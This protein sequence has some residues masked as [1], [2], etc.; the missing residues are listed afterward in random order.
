MAKIQPA[1]VDR[2]RAMFAAHR[3]G[4]PCPFNYGVTPWRDWLIAPGVGAGS[5]LWFA[6]PKADPQAAPKPY[7]CSLAQVKANLKAGY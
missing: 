1:V 6:V 7:L 4:E 3:A 2:A 5:G